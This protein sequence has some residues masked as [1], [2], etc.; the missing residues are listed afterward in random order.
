MKENDDTKR[1]KRPRASSRWVA[2]FLWFEWSMEWVVYWC[3]RVSFFKVLE[4]L[5]KLSIVTGVILYIYEAPERK[6]RAMAD[7]WLLVNSG[8]SG[9]GLAGRY[10]SLQYLAQQGAPLEGVRIWISDLSGV[11]FRK[12]NLRRTYIVSS[13][14]NNANLA[15]ADL[16]DSDLQN[17]SFLGA[18]L[19]G[20]ML[21][22][23]NLL[24]T[25]FRDSVGLK[26][27]QIKSA[28]R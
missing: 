18:N 14:L 15:G 9:Q 27:E 20:A 3:S 7:A 12:A 2:P 24:C 5:G 6:Q 21:T 1:P 11:D 23:A 26:A 22:N 17:T 10:Y 25:N 19:S 4:Y 16:S 13:K 28:R 8:N